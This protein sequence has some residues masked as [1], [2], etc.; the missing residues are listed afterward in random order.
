MPGSSLDNLKRIYSHPQGLF[1]CARFLE[2]YPHWEQVPSYDTAGSVALISQMGKKENAAIASEE[3]AKVYKMM[4]L[5]EGIETNVQNYT[6]FVVIAREEAPQ[7]KN[8]NKVSMVFSTPDKPGALF[9]ALQVLA[10]KNLNMKKLES[11]LSPGKPWEY[12]FYVDVEIPSDYDWFSNASDDLK[13]ETEDL[14]I[15]G[16]YCI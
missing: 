2:K 12:M 9:L 1:Q 4:I 8:P 16:I 13:K 5:K 6:R 10:E 15:L 11:R 14:R 3:A 7:I